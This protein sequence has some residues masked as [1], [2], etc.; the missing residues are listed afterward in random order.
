MMAAGVDEDEYPLRT[1]E[2][3]AHRL[4]GFRGNA[5]AKTPSEPLPEPQ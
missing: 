3:E 1:T 5:P 4:E 2:K